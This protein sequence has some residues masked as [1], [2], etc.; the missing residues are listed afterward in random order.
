MGGATAGGAER[1]H[2]HLYGQRRLAHAAVTEHHQL[3]QSQLPRHGGKLPEKRQDEV[4][5]GLDCAVAQV[6]FAW[7]ARGTVVSFPAPEPGALP[8]SVQ[9]DG[10]GGSRSASRSSSSQAF[11]KERTLDRIGRARTQSRA[12]GAL[13]WPHRWEVLAAVRY[14]AAA[15]GRGSAVAPIKLLVHMIRATRAFAGHRPNS[16]R[17]DGREE[18]ASLGP[19]SKR[20]ATRA[21]RLFWSSLEV[22]ATGFV[23]VSA[24]DLI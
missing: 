11:C 22:I 13:R 17:A 24:W 1:E 20:R 16:S 4:R 18:A 2:T 3:V 9:D 12:V 7:M 21:G 8:P 14:S 23:E 19:R 15:E 10:E 6:G 5:A